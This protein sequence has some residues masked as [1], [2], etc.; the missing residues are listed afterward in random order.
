MYLCPNSGRIV[1]LYHNM[2]VTFPMSTPGKYSN[3]KLAMLDNLYE[4]PTLYSKF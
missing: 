4:K 2:F 1:P 3:D